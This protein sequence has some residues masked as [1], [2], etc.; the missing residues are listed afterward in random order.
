M[1]TNAPPGHVAVV[2]A[3]LAG[4]RTCAALRA[5]GFTGTISVIGAEEIGPYDRPP[6]SKELFSRPEPAWLE[7]ELGQV[8][9]HL[10]DEVVLGVPATGLQSTDTGPVLDLAGGRALRADAVVL[11]CGSVPLNPWPAALALHTVG[12]AAALRNRL[13]GTGAHLLIV[14]AGWIGAEVAGVA[15]AAGARVTVVEA[16]AEPLSRQVPAVLGRRTRPWY[17][18][19]GVT[20]R[21]GTSVAGVHEDGVDVGDGE[22]VAADV[23]LAAV[24]VVPATAWLAGSVPLGARGHVL[25]DTDGR[26]QVPGIWAVGDC[27]WRHDPLFGQVPGG[28]WS[29]ALHDP[30][31]MVAAMLGQEVP[32]PRPAPF[33]YSTQLGHHLSVFGRVEGEL[34]IR[35]YDGGSWTALVLEA[36]TLVGAVIADVPRDV[37][38]V[39][40]LLG[41]GTLPRLDREAAADPA[42][43][44]RRTALG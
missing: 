11:A 21:T 23:V 27:A 34:L 6:L 22:Q 12:D 36:D 4:L 19:A 31:R 41:A 38:A 32:E 1:N 35:D 40:R 24:G 5:H 15:A 26:S 43:R 9:H 20:L 2:G 33:I 8:L 44:L 13:A 14:G 42:V 29:A 25:T 3:G 39:R 37:S 17:A 18:D 10:A 30:D 7:A 28:H 16:A